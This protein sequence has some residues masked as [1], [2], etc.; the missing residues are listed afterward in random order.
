[1]SSSHC[2]IV[3]QLFPSSVARASFSL[4]KSLLHL[5]FISLLL[6]VCPS[7]LPR[8]P[9]FFHLHTLAALFHLYPPWYFAPLLYHLQQGGDKRDEGGAGGGGLDPNLDNIIKNFRL[10]NKY[11]KK[12]KRRRS[13]LNSLSCISDSRS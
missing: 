2:V 1:M 7:L 4:P 11:A 8:C 12:K 5:H 3:L 10:N 13:L 9:V 6:Y